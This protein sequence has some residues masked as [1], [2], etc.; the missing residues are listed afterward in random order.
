MKA[1]TLLEPEYIIRYFT[2]HEADGKVFQSEAVHLNAWVQEV[3]LWSV[4]NKPCYKLQFRHSQIKQ[5][6]SLEIRVCVG[7]ERS[8]E[9]R[10]LRTAVP[11]PKNELPVL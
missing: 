6:N 1:K 10:E 4:E 9:R 11:S 8:A 2:K 7:E 3:L 5:R